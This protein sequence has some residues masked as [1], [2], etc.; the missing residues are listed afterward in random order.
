MTQLYYLTITSFCAWQKQSE[1]LQFSGSADLNSGYQFLSDKI[2]PRG[3]G[4]DHTTDPPLAV[5]YYKMVRR[6]NLDGNVSVNTVHRW[7]YPTF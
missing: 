6:Y 4:V 2:L 7:A 3:C 5:A 1:A